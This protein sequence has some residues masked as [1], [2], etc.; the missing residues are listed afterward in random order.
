[1]KV[2]VVESK[3]ERILERDGLRRMNF[4]ILR[5]GGIRITTLIIDVIE[6]EGS[7]WSCL[8]SIL[9]I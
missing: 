9:Q 6:V 2:L 1:M 4:M 8:G 3:R 7:M 5:L